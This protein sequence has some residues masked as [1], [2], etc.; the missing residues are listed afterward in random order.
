M[1]LIQ[2]YGGRGSGSSRPAWLT[3]QVPGQPELVHRETQYRKNEK[4]WGRIE[5]IADG[6]EP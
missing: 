6:N 2:H 3:E 4:M 1:S 5:C